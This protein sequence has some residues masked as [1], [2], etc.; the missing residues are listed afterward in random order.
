MKNMGGVD[1]ADQYCVTYRFLRRTLK[2]WRKLFFWGLEVLQLL[3][4]IFCMWKVARIAN[5]N[6]MSHIKVRRE[7]VMAR[8]GD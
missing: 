7:P 4:H 3:M 2:W 6:P 5:S 1:T 8:V